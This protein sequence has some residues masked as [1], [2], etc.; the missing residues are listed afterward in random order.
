M[1]FSYILDQII[2][3]YLIFSTGSNELSN[4]HGIETVF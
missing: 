1:H 3:W 2:V 4:L